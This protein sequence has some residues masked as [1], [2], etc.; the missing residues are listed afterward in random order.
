MPFLDAIL[1]PLLKLPVLWLVIALSLFISLIVTWIYKLTTDQ[2]LMKKLKDE[3]KAY[4][5]QIKAERNN[6]ARAMELNKKAMQ[7]NMQYMSHSMKSTLYTFIPIILLFSWMSAHLAFEPI[8]P[9]TEFTVSASFDKSTQGK[10]ELNAPNGII[11]KDDKIKEIDNGIAIWKLQGKAGEYLL[12]FKFNEE[13]HNK[14]LVITQ[15]NIYAPQNK[16]IKNSQLQQIIINNA[17]KKLINLFGWKI[18]WLGTYIIFSL[19]FSM[20]LRKVMKVY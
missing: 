17:Q 15:E 20:G 10:A 6:P 11:L 3:I 2:A 19:V 1:N 14:E 7:S 5:Q 18:G 8:K 13:A 16:K 4:Q 12:E 9:D